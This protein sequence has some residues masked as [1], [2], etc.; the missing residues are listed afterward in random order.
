MTKYPVGYQ[1]KADAQ[2]GVIR[3]AVSFEDQLFLDI[4]TMAKR[5]KRTFS[6]MVNELCKCG[7][8]CLYE[9]DML[10]VA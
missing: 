8:L 5:E 4:I 10:E 9:S 7:K 2:N 6:E 1:T 3:C